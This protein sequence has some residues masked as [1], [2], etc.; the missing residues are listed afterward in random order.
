MSLRRIPKLRRDGRAFAALAV[1]LLLGLT[2]APARAADMA[3]QRA[4]YDLTLQSARG[5]II[6]ASGTMSYEVQDV[7]DGWA[8]QQRLSMALTNRDGQD[9]QMVSDYATW[10]SKDG[11]HMRF[12]MRQTTDTAVTSEVT[13]EAT[14]QPDGGPGEVKYA[15]PQNTMKTLPKG[16]LFP[17]AHTEKIIAAARG[18]QKFL[19]LP[20]FDGTGPDGAQDSSIAITSWR[21]PQPD[22]K[23]PDLGPLASTTVHVAFFDRTPD[24]QQ[25]TYEVGMRY[26]ENGVADDLAMDFGNFVMAGKMTQ[27]KLLPSHC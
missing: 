1:I 2:A 20:L 7:C 26:W 22:Q 14:L 19:A 10:E 25:P 17:T 24:A 23:W 4:L 6:A 9:I 11:L 16:T 8:T 18:G 3:A 27:L 5:D 15:L 21:K 13:G 12:R